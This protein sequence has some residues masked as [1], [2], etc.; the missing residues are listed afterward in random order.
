[1]TFTLVQTVLRRLVDSSTNG[2]ELKGA[3]L[4]ILE[5]LEQFAVENKMQQ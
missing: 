5:E 1:M 4:R 3:Y 2:S